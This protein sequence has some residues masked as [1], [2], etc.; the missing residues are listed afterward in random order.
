M[1]VYQEREK[2]TLAFST[3]G[4]YKYVEVK[5]EAKGVLFHSASE[6]KEI[7]NKYAK[8]GYSYVGF[9]PTLIDAHGGF[10]R[11]DLIFEK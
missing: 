6:P 7:I 10:R 1:K 11:I 3:R 8:E 4:R 2:I 5:F 9:I